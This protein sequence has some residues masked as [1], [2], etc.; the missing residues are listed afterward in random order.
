MNNT[1]RNRTFFMSLIYGMK[2]VVVSLSRKCTT[3]QKRSY[4]A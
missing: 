1:E 2:I 3:L 4:F